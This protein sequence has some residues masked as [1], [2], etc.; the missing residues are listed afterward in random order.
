MAA[1]NV[2]H[3]VTLGVIHLAPKRNVDVNERVNFTAAMFPLYWACLRAGTSGYPKFFSPQL[4]P[5][6]EEEWQGIISWKDN[7]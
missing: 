6:G 4:G 3:M 2:L 5:V 1:K 7:A